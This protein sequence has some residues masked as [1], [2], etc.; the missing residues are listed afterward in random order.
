META[1]LGVG[2]LVLDQGFGEVLGL[3]LCLVEERVYT[4]FFGHCISII[5]G[6]IWE[7]IGVC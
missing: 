2:F 6:Y 5:I 3:V 7:N 1:G 4:C